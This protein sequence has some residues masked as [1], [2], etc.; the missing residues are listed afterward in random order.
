MKTYKIM[1]TD[2]GFIDSVMADKV[3]EGENT[4]IL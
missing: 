3:I 4:A 1:T 2:G